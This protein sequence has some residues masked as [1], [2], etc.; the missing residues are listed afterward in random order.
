MARRGGV[1]ARPARR[2][3]QKLLNERGCPTSRIAGMTGGAS[4]TGR[5]NALDHGHA[6]Q[7]L[8]HGKRFSFQVNSESPIVSI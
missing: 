4:L 8:G 2:G 1:A 7:G 5:G 3:V 6:Q